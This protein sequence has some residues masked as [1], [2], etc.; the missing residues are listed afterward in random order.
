MQ[1]PSQRS[2]APRSVCILCLRGTN[3]SFFYN[4]LKECSL[5][6]SLNSI[7]GTPALSTPMCYVLFPTLVSEAQM[8]FAFPTPRGI[9]V[10]FAYLAAITPSENSTSV[11][12][13]GATLPY[14]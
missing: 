8:S 11:F 4:N 12:L 10:V 9:A 2:L 3:S 5:I 13:W 7:Y 6:Q 1:A 14:S